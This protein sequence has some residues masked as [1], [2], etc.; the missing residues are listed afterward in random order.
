MAEPRRE[1]PL[2]RA[3]GSQPNRLIEWPSL[4]VE[5]LAFRAIFV[6]HGRTGVPR[7]AQGVARVLGRPAAGRPQHLRRDRVRLGGGRDCMDGSRGVAR[8]RPGGGDE[9]AAGRPPAGDPGNG[10]GGGR[11]KQRLHPVLDRGP[12]GPATSSRPAAPSTFTPAR[13]VPAAARRPSS[14]GS[15][16]SPRAAARRDAALRDDGAPQLR[17]VALAMDGG[18]GRDGRGRIG[19]MGESAPGEHISPM[20]CCGRQSTRGG[21]PYSL[22]PLQRSVD[23]VF[24]SANALFRSVRPPTAAAWRP[25]DEHR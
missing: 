7:F 6:L 24:S 13:S 23:Y 8:D 10:R 25:R 16:E 19:G 1:S 18:V 14:P 22:K 20:S 17:A 9:R 4:R 11:S 12:A 21:G 5:E 15:P 3:P 2:G